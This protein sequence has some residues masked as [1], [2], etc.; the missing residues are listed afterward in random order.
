VAGADP[1]GNFDPATFRTQIR[2]TMEMGL[3][4][5]T[6]Y[7]PTFR[8]TNKRDFSVGDPS[9]RPYNWFQ[10]AEGNSP[11]VIADIVV[12]CAIQYSGGSEDGT[13]AGFVNELKVKLTILDEDV[14]T[15]LANGNNTWPD[16]VLLKNEPYNI[17]Y[18]PVP[19]GLFSVDV[20][21]VYASAQDVA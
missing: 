21:E 17:D 15:L 19:T 8:W 10:T 7:Q 3:S 1:T 20:Y 5:T 12:P 2:A 18:V 4:N 6:A 16:Q 13:E 9:D 14:D 11:A